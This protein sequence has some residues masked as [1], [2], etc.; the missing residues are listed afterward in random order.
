MDA[1]TDGDGPSVVTTVAAVC[2]SGL[3]YSGWQVLQTSTQAVQSVV[4]A[5]GV[6][7]ELIVEKTTVGFIV[8]AE[9][10]FRAISIGFAALALT[11]MLVK[12]YRGVALCK[13]LGKGS[14]ASTDGDGPS[15]LKASPKLF[16]M[17]TPD[18]RVEP[19]SPPGCWPTTDSV[20]LL[21]GRALIK[22]QR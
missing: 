5:G 13:G 21:A 19:D 18:A 9:D 3:A 8:A 20:Y 6:A 4:I 1:S 12:V 16:D 7:V 14:S 22:K 15:P 10:S 11:W 17:S 2:T